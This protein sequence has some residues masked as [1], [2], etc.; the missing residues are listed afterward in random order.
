M[1][2][3]ISFFLGSIFGL[4]TFKTIKIV[5]KIYPYF[6]NNNFINSSSITTNKIAIISGSTDGLGKA[7]TKKLY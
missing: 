4:I 7:F 3:P 6:I 1:V 5:H 2:D